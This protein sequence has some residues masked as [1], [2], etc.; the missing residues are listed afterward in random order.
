MEQFLGSKESVRECLQLLLTW[1]Q[2]AE[3]SLGQLLASEL[4]RLLVALPEGRKLKL[5]VGNNADR[6]DPAELIEALARR[7]AVEIALGIE[8][9][10]DRKKKQQ[11]LSRLLELV[12]RD[13]AHLAQTDEDQAAL[14][15]LEALLARG[16]LDVRAYVRERLPV[17]FLLAHTSGQPSTAL[18]GGSNLLAPEF[19]TETAL[20]MRSRSPELVAGLRERFGSLWEESLPLREPLLTELRGS[21]ALQ[22]TT[23]YLLYLS[24]LYR[25]VAERLQ[26]EEEHPDPADWLTASFPPLADFQLVA[27]QQALTILNQYRGVFVA[28]VVGLGKTYIG[29]ALLKRLKQ[30]GQRATIFCPP[31]LAPMWSEM[32]SLFD[33]GAEV[34]STGRL[35]VHGPKELQ[36]PK[37]Q[38]ADRQVVLIDESHR[39]RNMGT[40]SYKA[41]AEYT[42]GRAVVLLTATPYSLRARDVYHQVRLFADDELD[43]GLNPPRLGEFF[44]AIDSGKASLV[45]V[46]RPLLIRRTR[47]H[48]QKH[49]PDSQISG[50]KLVFPTREKPQ[51]VRYDVESVF[52]STGQSAMYDYI[53]TML[54]RPANE[55]LSPELEALGREIPM[56]TY[57]RYGL[58]YY[59]RPAYRSVAPYTDLKQTSIAVKGFI[60]ILMFK[61]LESSVEAIRQTVDKMLR[62]HDNFLKA[63]DK[64]FVPAGDAA[65]R[66]LYEQDW[67]D[68]QALGEALE[69]TGTRYD[70]AHFDLERLR[71]DLENDINVLAELKALLKPIT[72]KKDGKLTE[73]RQLLTERLGNKKVLVF[74]QFEATAHYLAENLAELPQVA[75]LSGQHRGA[76]KSFL[77]TIARFA[78]KANPLFADAAANPIR[79]LIATDVLS[80]G[81]NLQD[82]SVLVNYDLTYNP[83]RLIQRVGRVDRVGSEA[84]SIWSYNFLPER[85]VEKVLGL[86]EVLKRRIGEIHTFIGEDSAILTPDEQLNESDMYAAYQSSPDSEADPE[87]AAVVDFTEIEERIRQ[88]QRDDPELFQKIRDLPAGVRSARKS[89]DSK[90]GTFV[91]FTTD[92]SFQELSLLDSTGKIRSTRL[93]DVLEAIECGPDEPELPLPT[94]HNTHVSRAFLQFQELAASRQTDQ[95][96]GPRLGPGQQ[97]ALR[98]LE[99]A[100]KAESNE[101]R[102]LFLETLRQALRSRLPEAAI[103]D[104]NRL[105]RQALATEEYLDRLQLLYRDMDLGRFIKKEGEAPTQPVARIVCNEGLVE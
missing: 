7:D 10:P 72:P 97:L 49:Y 22:T 41:L 80:E 40:E 91:F 102:K 42:Q 37:Y 13:L 39:F 84:E 27:V 95:R 54:G 14:R 65:Q 77:R 57:A 3:G 79:V 53:K 9:S 62:V 33:L 96:T 86:E 90:A 88:L 70:P 52:G 50:K 46:L 59:V 99:L 6:L 98:H 28:D 51:V 93:E 71:R 94:R 35:A 12:R 25:L 105:R 30:R 16:E 64:G 23:P 58:Y 17:D 66:L 34:F 43:L 89:V 73:L 55:P 67:S 61:R 92:T 78:P 101:D 100:L 69:A 56:M 104:L 5:L 87:S 4:A 47:K 63:L 76:G 2:S 18:W 19:L 36:E 21:W 26:Q 74:T 29:T 8:R 15:R 83:V 85:N 44:G 68:E 60:R 81:L 103:R 45:D 48:I 32:N 20:W 24:V 1:G 75:W 38:T 31:A 11:R 82:C